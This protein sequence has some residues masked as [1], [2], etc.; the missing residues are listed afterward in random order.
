MQKNIRSWYPTDVVKSFRAPNGSD[1]TWKTECRSRN[2]NKDSSTLFG[3]KFEI[4]ETSVNAK[5]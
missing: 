4:P 5:G 2:G 3:E 1:Y